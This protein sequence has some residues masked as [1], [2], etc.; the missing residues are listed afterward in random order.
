MKRELQPGEADVLPD[1][2]MRG[3]AE[4]LL[5]VRMH[6]DDYGAGLDDHSLLAEVR[7]REYRVRGVVDG[8]IVG[9][10]VYL[11]NF[12][13]RMVMNP[14]PPG[15]PYNPFEATFRVPPSITKLDIRGYLHAVYGLDVTYIRTVIYE[16]FL[17]KRRDRRTKR[18]GKS[19]HP[20]YKRVTVGLTEPFYYP[21][22]LEDMSTE[23]R[24]AVKSQWE[25]DFHPDERAVSWARELK[26]SFQGLPP[27]ADVETRREILERI[28]QRR[29]FRASQ[30]E[31]KLGGIRAERIAREEARS[32]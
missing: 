22:M 12:L 3:E 20:T 18:L 29:A 10:R 31:D 28:A 15:H 7:A 6:R 14:T 2:L 30:L 19:L 23:E 4:R 9:K 25:K 16:G 24:D 26:R 21:L 17:A 11:P 5:R 8:R 1:G 13:F 27:E 32:A